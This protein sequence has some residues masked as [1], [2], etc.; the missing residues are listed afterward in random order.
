MN[1]RFRQDLLQA[2]RRDLTEETRDL[3]DEEILQIID[4]GVVRGRE[5]GISGVRDVSMFVY[6]MILY[7]RRF[8]EAPERRWAKKILLKHD[9]QAEAK[10]S[11]LY[12]MLAAREGSRSPA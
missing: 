8:E 4:D 2:A 12:Q 3:P 10:M 6:L 9:M 11:L 7:G 1:E 5:Y